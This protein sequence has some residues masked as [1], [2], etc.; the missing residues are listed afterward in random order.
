MPAEPLAKGD[1]G[2]ACWANCAS[3]VERNCTLL[4]VTSTRAEPAT[5]VVSLPSVWADE[6]GVPSGSWIANEI[7][8]CAVSIVNTSGLATDRAAK[9]E[10]T[11][12]KTGMVNNRL[13]VR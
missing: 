5:L 11:T 6:I 3:P 7:W 12:V 10:S 1:C 4:P 13:I 2:T 8:L 9:T